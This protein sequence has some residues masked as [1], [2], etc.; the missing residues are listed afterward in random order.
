MYSNKYIF[1]GRISNIIIRSAP[2]KSLILSTDDKREGDSTI[3][4]NFSPVDAWLWI[5]HCCFTVQSHIIT[6]CYSLVPRCV[7][8]LWRNWK[9]GNT[10]FTQVKGI[11]RHKR[12]LKMAEERVVNDARMGREARVRFWVMFQDWSWVI[13]RSWSHPTEQLNF[14]PPPTCCA[15]SQMFKSGLL[16]FSA[17]VLKSG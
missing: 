2:K 9:K 14:F 17:T 7:C 16:V 8:Y 15:A 5:P 3:V 4:R 1:S 13:V 11:Y 12:H 6:L 10:G